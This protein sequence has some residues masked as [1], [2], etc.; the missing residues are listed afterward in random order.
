MLSVFK[1]FVIFP[2]FLSQSISAFYAQSGQIHLTAKNIYGAKTVYIFDNWKYHT[3]DSASWANPGY[4]DTSWKTADSR[5]SGLRGMPAE[6]W[7][8]IGWFRLHIT[9]DSSLLYKP[10]GFRMRQ[11]GASEVYLNGKLLFKYGKVGRS[12]NSEIIKKVLVPDGIVF[13]KVSGNVLAIR[14]S[15]FCDNKM[16]KNEYGLGFFIALDSMERTISNRVFWSVWYN[17]YKYILIVA[18]F[19][20]GLFHFVLFLYDTS[21]KQNLYFVLLSA[22]F[23]LYA[24]F[25]FQRNLVVNPVNYVYFATLSSIFITLLILFILLTLYSIFYDKLP[26]SFYFFAALAAVFLLTKIFFSG[27]Y[28]TYIALAYSFLSFTEIA[29]LAVLRGLGKSNGKRI[30]SIGAVILYISVIYHYLVQ[31]GVVTNIGGQYLIY[32]YGMIALL[33]SISIYMAREFAKTNERLQIK[34]QEVKQLSE[35]TLRQEIEAKKSE[36]EKHIL[37]NDNRRKTEELEEARQLQL[38]MLPKKIPSPE[39]LDISVHMQTASEVGGDYYDFILNDDGTLTVALGD[40]TGHGMRAGIM[41]AS[42]KSLFA[43]FGNIMDI[44]SFFNRCTEIIKSMHLWNLYMAMMIVKIKDYKI[45][46]SAAGMPPIFIHRKKENKVEEIVIKGMPLGGHNDFPYQEVTTALYPGDTILLQ[47]DGYPEL[48]NTDREML[49][50][51]RTAE[52]FHDAADLSPDNIIKKMISAGEKWQ[53]GRAQDDDI[54]FI[55]MRIK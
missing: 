11:N 38:S 28:V 47:S 1:Y 21:S 37:E 22:A 3:G 45:T 5:L 23:A 48:F 27:G 8:G 46:A 17:S 34:L 31:F 9:V 6:G 26:Y 44:T 50:Y 25:Y 33:I 32:I 53:N 4:N 41:V 18:A 40:A 30:I 49:D 12:A 39:N 36:L 7:K 29:R 52:I 54:T 35:K 10:V 24:Y 19:F 55:V 51:A 20:L 15:N 14:Y 43:A 2:L 16:M 42:M 13:T